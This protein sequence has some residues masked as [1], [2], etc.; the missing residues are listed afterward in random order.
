MIFECVFNSFVIT[1]RSNPDPQ[2][3]TYLSDY[4]FVVTLHVGWKGNAMLSSNKRQVIC[5]PVYA[6][7]KV[8]SFNNCIRNLH[9]IGYNVDR[10]NINKVFP[11]Q[12]DLVDLDNLIGKLKRDCQ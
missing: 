1:G 2:Q 5:V 9:D 3:I 8:K 11:A 7:S 10:R 4:G 12:I 6:V